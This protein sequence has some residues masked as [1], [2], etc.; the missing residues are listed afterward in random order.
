[1]QR[2]VVHEEAVA[3]LAVLAER[4]A[5]VG[6]D[7]DD[8]R[9]RA[10]VPGGQEIAERV[11]GGR[12]LA[13]VRVAAAMRRRRVVRSVR[14]EQVDPHEARS[15]FD[16][17]PCARGRDHVGTPALG[18]LVVDARRFL[19][20]VVVVVE[21]ARQAEPRGDGKGADERGGAQAACPQGLGERRRLRAQRPRAV[22]RTPC[23]G[24]RRPVITVVC[25]GS[26]SGAGA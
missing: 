26:V 5:V 7:R 16:R 14:I 23:A 17:E 10:R 22:A 21:P 2:D 9:T 20:R 1:V 24:G 12:D 19:D 8:G 6:G 18:E 4:L 11:V 3:L 15:R 13:A 25:E